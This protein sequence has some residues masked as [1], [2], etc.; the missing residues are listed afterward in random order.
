[1]SEDDVRDV[2]SRMLRAQDGVATPDLQLVDGD[3]SAPSEQ[4]DGATG[5]GHREPKPAD[6]VVTEIFARAGLDPDAQ[7]VAEP[8]RRALADKGPDATELDQALVDVA[9]RLRSSLENGPSQ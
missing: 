6:A 4:E 2:E 8:V 3:S 5:I 7:H 9:S 1:M